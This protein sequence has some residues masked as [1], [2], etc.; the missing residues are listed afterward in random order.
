MNSR[1]LV[2]CSPFS[3]NVVA[4]PS[5]LFIPILG[6]MYEEFVFSLDC[7]LSHVPF[8]KMRKVLSTFRFFLSSLGGEVAFSSS[9]F[10]RFSCDTLLPFMISYLYLIGL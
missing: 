9:F 3:Y 5:F 8:D 4:L 10:Y 7:R 1:N 2:S 6:S